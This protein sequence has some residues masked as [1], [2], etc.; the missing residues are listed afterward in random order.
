M[1]TLNLPTYNFRKETDPE[2]LVPFLK[3]YLYVQ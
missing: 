1:F 2:G 3:I